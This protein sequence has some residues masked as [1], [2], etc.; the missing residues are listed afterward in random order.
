MD[1]QQ[2][3]ICQWLDKNEH[4]AIRLLQKLVEQ[5]STQGNEAAAQAIV[6]EKCRQIGLSIDVWE[7]GG[8]KLVQHQHFS[9]TRTN[10]KESPNIAAVWKGSG[11]GKSLLFNGHID[12]VPEGDPT[13][14]VHDPYTPKFEDGK[15]YGRGTSDMKGGNAAMLMAI[16]ALV[17]CRAELKGDLIFQSVIEEESGGAGTLDA[18]LRGY[19]ADGAIIPEP[20]K[21]K[22]FPKQQGSMWFKVAVRGKSAHGGTRYEGVSAIEKAMIVI[23][24]F[25]ELEKL[26]NVRITDPLYSATPIPVPINIGKISG[27]TWP[28]SVPDEVILEGRCGIAPDEQPEEVQKEVQEYLS[29][30]PE[31]DSWFE[32][33][34]VSLQWFGARWLPNSLEPDHP[35]VKGLASSCRTVT[36]KDPV[37]EASPWGTDGGMLAAAGG[38]PTVVFGPG[39]TETAHHPNEYIPIKNVMES[40]KIMALFALNWCRAD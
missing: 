5:P 10:F 24:C 31:H 29:R 15:V 1:Q 16:E 28:S 30:L 3:A 17:K 13:Q 39:I 38:I 35:L 19:R 21:M 20:T 12:V 27:G 25:R 2:A 23:R 4:R 7:P 32:E 6:L 37:L 26:R 33:H 11:G 40:A 9:S 34:P 8:K 14:W 36:G 18:I 22:I